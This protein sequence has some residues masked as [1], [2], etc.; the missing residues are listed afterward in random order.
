[1]PVWAL[2]DTL[3]I[4][5][6]INNINFGCIFKHKYLYFFILENYYYKWDE[7]GNLVVEH[8]TP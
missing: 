8:E 3:I 1:M 7:N 6:I 4:F 5:P 2:R